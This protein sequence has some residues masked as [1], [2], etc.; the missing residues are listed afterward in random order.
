MAGLQSPMPLH[1]SS[2]TR[3]RERRRQR[4]LRQQRPPVQAL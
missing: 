1:W 2:S 4:S 3:Q